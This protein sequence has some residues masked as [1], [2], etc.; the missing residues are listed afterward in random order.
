MFSLELSFVSLNSVLKV[1]LSIWCLGFQIVEL[2]LLFV[3]N[4]SIA[5][6]G[7]ELT[8]ISD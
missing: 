5:L 1:N 2:D 3:A 8:A 4:H 7:I 6:S